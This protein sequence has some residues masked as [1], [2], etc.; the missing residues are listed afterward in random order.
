MGLHDFT[1]GNTFVPD[2]I[3]S[4]FPDEVDV[5]QLQAAKA[6]AISMIQKAASLAL[7]PEDF[8][9]TVRVTNETGHKLPSGYPEGRRVWLNIKAYDALDQQVYESGA[10]DFST[11]VLTHDD[12]VKIYEILPG[13]S[14]ALASALGQPAG[15][16]FHFVLSDTVF[17]DNR[18]PPRGFTNAGFVAIQSPPVAYSYADGQHWDDTEYH[19]PVE[20]ESVYVTLY[21]QTTT[22]EYVEFLRDANTTNSAGQDL[23]DAWVAQGKAPPVVI[24]EAGV[25]VEVT[26]TGV[27]DGAVAYRY[28]LTQNRPNPFNPTTTIGYSLAADGH[29][30]LA[31]YDVA[32]RLVRTLVDEIRPAGRHA[33]VWNGTDDSGRDVATG[34]YFVRYTAGPETFWRKAALLR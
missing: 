6:R 2:I 5:G 19:L 12:D 14:P 17:F 33:V 23:Y 13:I 9:V 29:A 7:T 34:L 8:G 10:Y 1:G 4:Y 18:I 25:G 20:A 3:A 15:K 28:E 16:S 11:A 22:K 24:A 32:G 26:D 21:Y 30:F 27:S 31:V